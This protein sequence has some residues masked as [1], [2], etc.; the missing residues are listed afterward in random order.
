MSFDLNFQQRSVIIC[1]STI[2]FKGVSM[3]I[4]ALLQGLALKIE[5]LKVA[6]ADSQAA[7]DSI[8][9]EAYAKG[10]ADG[11]AS[12]PPPVDDV[13]PFSQADLDAA[14]LAAVEPLQAQVS[15]MQGEMEALKL[16]VEELQMGIEA[17]KVEA[18]AS[19]KAELAVKYAELQVVEQAA[20]TGFAELL[21]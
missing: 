21:K 14:V 8:A 18:V 15:A 1:Q 16:Q 17:A 6:L 12:V 3:D 10:F 7:A 11:V 4:I 20:E 2:Y 13:T 5:E 19:F 9:A